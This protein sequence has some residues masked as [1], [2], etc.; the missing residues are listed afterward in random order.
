MDPDDFKLFFPQMMKRVGF[1]PAGIRL[2]K[3]RTRQMLAG[4]RRLR[5]QGTIHI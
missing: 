1:T 2:L 5:R 4:K 3:E